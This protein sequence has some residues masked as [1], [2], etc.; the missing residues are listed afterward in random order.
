MSTPSK[1][2]SIHD[3]ARYV[4]E[5]LHRRSVLP[6]SRKLLF[7]TIDDTLEPQLARINNDKLIIN[8][9]HK[10]LKRLDEAEDATVEDLTPKDHTLDIDD[11]GSFSV[12]ARGTS[13]NKV[14][15][16]DSRHAQVSLRR[17][18]VTLE[19]LRSR[20]KQKGPDLTWSTQPIPEQQTKKPSVEANG[21][22][23][24][25]VLLGSLIHHKAVS[26]AVLGHMIDFLQSC[27]GYLYTRCVHDCGCQLPPK[28]QLDL[29]DNSRKDAESGLS[30]TVQKLQELLNDWYDIAKLLQDD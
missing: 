29:P 15:K 6:A 21:D 11:N 2:S 14:V 25:T 27:N 12:K 16:P 22:E 24:T 9:I 30:E 7:P 13:E 28:I 26:A 5:E 10:L 4:N 19:Q 18:E 20:L 3:A 17:Y 23:A 8:T 1:F